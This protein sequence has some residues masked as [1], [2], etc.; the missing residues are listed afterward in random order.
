MTE[1]AV[2]EHAAP[3][4]TRRGRLQGFTLVEMLVALLIFA[5][6]SATGVSVLAY[7]ADN[8]GVAQARMERLGEFQ[9]A[10]SLLKSDLGQAAVRRARQADGT[11]AR[12]SFIGAGARGPGPLLALVR[13]G[14]SN[15]DAQPRASMQYVEYRLVDG[16]LERSARPALDGAPTGAPQV[17]LAGIES[18]GIE[19]RYRGEWLDGWPGGAEAMPEAI[20]LELQLAGIGR[21]E[22]LFLLPA[23]G[24]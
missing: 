21:V 3:L 14:W 24:R 22:Q 19:Y 5:G 7:A 15:P 1:H 6:I 9:R 13:R 20:R 12:N 2:T 23:A 11:A 8:R 18:G 10:R 16:R 4:R 17:L